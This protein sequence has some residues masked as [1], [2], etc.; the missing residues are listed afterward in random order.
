MSKKPVDWER[1][2][3]QKEPKDMP[4]YHA[5]EGKLPN[6]K[7]TA[8]GFTS[9]IG[10]MLIGAQRAKFSVLGNLEWRHYYRLVDPDYRNTFTEN[11]PGAFFSR[12][13]NDLPTRDQELL[14]DTQVDLAMGHPEC[15]PKGTPIW[16]PKGAA[17]IQDLKV[18]DA[19][20]TSK[21]RFRE[22]VKTFKRLMK[23]G[24]EMIRVETY[25][26][27]LEVSPLHP[28]WTEELGWTPAKHLTPGLTLRHY[29][30]KLGEFLKLRVQ[31]VNS[32]LLKK[33]I[34]VYNLGV[35]E[36]ESYLAKNILVHNCG[37]YSMLN[38]ANK[39]AKAQ[40]KQAGDIPLFLNYVAQ[41][42]PRFFV[43]DD[44]PKSFVA[45]PMSAY[46][47]L[48]PDYDLFPEWISNYHYGNIQLNR[49]RMFMIGALKEEGFVFVPGER[50]DHE[51]RTL[52]DKIGDLEGRYGE[53]PNHERHLPGGYSS[54]FLHMRHRGDRPSW[55]EVAQHFKKQKPLS[56]LA[57]YKEDGSMTMRPSLARLKYDHHCWVLTGG[58]PLLHPV[59]GYPLSIRERAT[60]QGFPDDFIFYGIKLD[61]RGRWEHNNHNLYLVKQTGKAMPIEFNEFVAKQIA[62]HLQGKKVR[63]SNRRFLKVSPMIDEA[64]REFCSI[65]GYADQERACEHCWMNETCELPRR[66]SDLF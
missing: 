2:L 57:Y 61:K 50:E 8:L 46:A 17:R 49:K 36:D 38:G 29:N 53:V 31:E 11:F 12:G 44:L 22:I 34:T 1:A 6:R 48:L 52:F 27:E 42:K 15:F 37:L 16:T 45:L 14:M 3:A 55:E 9:G 21:G 43:M 47:E 39:N 25:Q 60:I 20:L 65:S 7:L 5:P 66:N 35:D 33:D 62:D 32:F 51:A 24:D 13:W 4:L 58:N 64:K 10:S 56:N 30:E 26:T 63:A 23:K 59:T 54:R 28:F 18:G 40:V 41:F 19:V